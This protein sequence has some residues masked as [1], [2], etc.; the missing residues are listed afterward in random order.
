MDPLSITVSCVSLL[1]AVA[2]TSLGIRTFIRGCR[3]AREDLFGIT[4]D[5]SQLEFVLELLRDDIS[6]SDDHIIPKSLQDQ[7]LSIIINCSDVLQRIDVALQ[8]YSGK[9]GAVKWAAGYKKEE[10]EGIRSSVKAHCTSLNLLLELVSISYSKAIK[11]DTSAVRAEVGDVKGDTTQILEELECLRG[12]IAQSAGTNDK[13][14]LQKYL[15]DLATYAGTVCGDDDYQDYRHTEQEEDQYPK[16]GLEDDISAS[17]ELD[18]D[19]IS[20]TWFDSDPFRPSDHPPR[21]NEANSIHPASSPYDY[22]Q[23]SIPGPSRQAPTRSQ[24]QASTKLQAAN[25]R[26][27]TKDANCDC[28]DCRQPSVSSKTSSTPSLPASIQSRSTQGESRN[29][30][31]DCACDDCRG[32]PISARREGATPPR[33]APPTKQKTERDTPTQS[34]NRQLSESQQSPDKRLPTPPKPRQ[35]IRVL[36]IGD[37]CG[38]RSLC[39]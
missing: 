15:N 26:K 29:K 31:E 37:H 19:G 4:N 20:N 3:G 5:L 8:S 6:V 25:E 32:P 30:I 14:I 28:E 23:S 13:F 35:I 1:S 18:S 10:I 16:S 21:T 33:P 38:K 12:I 7:V 22:R 2:K 11:E 27:A 17:K 39:R 9:A 24:P 34:D 36:V